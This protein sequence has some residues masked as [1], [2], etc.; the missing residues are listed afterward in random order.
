MRA[1]R[2]MTLPP[3]TGAG[4]RSTQLLKPAFAFLHAGRFEAV[5]ECEQLSLEPQQLGACL[6]AYV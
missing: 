1:F 5:Q 2:S 3:R 4:R 6:A